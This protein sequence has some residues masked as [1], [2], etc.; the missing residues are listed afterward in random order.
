[1]LPPDAEVGGVDLAEMRSDGIGAPTTHEEHGCLSH[2][3]PP[4]AIDHE[5]KAAFADGVT[6]SLVRRDD[7][8]AN[9]VERRVS[10]SL[11]GM[12]HGAQPALYPNCETADALEMGAGVE[13]LAPASEIAC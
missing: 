8:S 9:A 6:R 2:R 10:S 5:S 1:V 4:V 11:I 7:T 3:A 13:K 12:T